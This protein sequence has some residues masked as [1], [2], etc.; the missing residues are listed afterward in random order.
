ML[1]GDLRV[2]DDVARGAR[3]GACNERHPPVDFLFGEFE[4]VQPFGFGEGV[5]FA[6]GA[7]WDKSC[8]LVGDQVFDQLFKDG[9]VDAFVRVEG[10]DDGGV[11]S[12]ELH[13]GLQLEGLKVIRW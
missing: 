5:D 6:R 1:L 7:A 2:A 12:F 11:Y 8:D 13:G 3:V 9:V 4:N 10:G